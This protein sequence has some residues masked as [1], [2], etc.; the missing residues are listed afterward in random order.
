MSDLDH[1]EIRRLALEVIERGIGTPEGDSAVAQAERLIHDMAST[2][3][4]TVLKEAQDSRN[5]KVGKLEDGLAQW[6]SDF[7]NYKRRTAEA[8]DVKIRNAIGKLLEDFLPLGDN[9]DRAAAAADGD[10]KIYEGIS[11]VRDAFKT[12]ITKHGIELIDAVGC[13][14]NPEVHEA[15]GTEETVHGAGVILDVLEQ[16]YTWRGRLLKPA[17]VIVST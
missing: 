17:K 10:P 16:G 8:E 3:L 1:D 7:E 6:K 12:A 15:I 13:Q 11:M 5:T 4:A 2:A 9:L 14:F